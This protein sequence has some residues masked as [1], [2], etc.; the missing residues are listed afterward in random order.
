AG[1]IKT[2]SVSRGERTAKHNELMRIEDTN[3]D[4]KLNNPFV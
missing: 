3:S 2:G 4:L 1:Q